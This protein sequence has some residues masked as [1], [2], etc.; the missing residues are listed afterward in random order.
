MSTPEQPVLA[1]LFTTFPKS[2]ETFIQREISGLIAN[3]LRPRLYSMHRGGGKFEGLPVQAFPKWKLIALLWTLPVEALRRPGVFAR[4]LRGLLSRRAPSWL[5]FWENMLAAGF[6]VVHARH[7]RRLQPAH[8]HAVWGGGPSTAAWLLWRLNGHPYSAAGHA[9]DLYR[10]GGDWWLAE[11]LQ[12][13]LFVH[14]S[15]DMGRRTLIERGIAEQRIHLIRRGLATLPSFKAL[16]PAP[17]QPLRL[18]CVARLVP[19]K[20]LDHQL[21]IYAALRDAGV[22]FEARIAGEGPLHSALTQQI[23]A[24]K[25]SAHVSLLG[26]RP[27]TEIA[28]LLQWADIMLHTGVIA[29]D[30]DRDGLPNVIPEAMASGVL[31]VTSPAAAT[32]EAITHGQTGLVAPPEETAAW[33]DA[34]RRLATDDALASRLRIHARAWVEQHFNAQQNA[35]RLAKL[36]RELMA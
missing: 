12:P 7:F 16:R 10:D 5:N 4:M 25:L 3:G 27:Q 8:I 13:A 29:G 33:V 1:Y 23:T 31:V 11:K 9:Y 21:R 18:L 19:K 2:T 15:T 35:G 32:T 28:A 6:A 34:F 24:L 17:R 36:Y 20:G 22:P 30:G 14:T 26:H